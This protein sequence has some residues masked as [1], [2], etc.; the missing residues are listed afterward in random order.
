MTQPKF[1]EGWDEEKLRRVVAHY[2][3][4]SDQDAEAEDCAAMESS[5]TVVSVPRSPAANS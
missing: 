1:P 3:N 4:Q 5:E 2:K